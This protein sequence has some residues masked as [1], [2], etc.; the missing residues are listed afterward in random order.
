MDFHLR[1]ARIEDMLRNESEPSLP[2]GRELYE[3]A[4]LAF[5]DIQPVI[6]TG[7]LMERDRHDAR[8]LASR[9]NLYE[10]VQGATQLLADEDWIKTE[11]GGDRRAAWDLLE[12]VFFNDFISTGGSLKCMLEL[13]AEFPTLEEWRQ[14]QFNLGSLKREYDRRREAQ[15]PPGPG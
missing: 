3:R 15:C 12:V 10:R 8:S 11:C 1:L 14:H 9:A 4:L 2:T 13:Y 5:D 7:G 6:D